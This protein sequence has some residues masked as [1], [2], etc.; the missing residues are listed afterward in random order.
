MKLPALRHV[1]SQLLPHQQRQALK[2]RLFAVRDMSTR[3]ANLKRAGFVPTGAIDGG[4]YHGDWAVEFWSVFPNS[5]VLLIEPQ[6]G[7]RETLNRLV[8]KHAG[9]LV[10]S[11]AVSADSGTADFVLG[12][13]NSFICSP[14]QA[15]CSTVS[16]PV[17][18]LDDILSDTHGF[19]P[20]LLKLDLQGHEIQALEGSV[21]CLDQ[22]EVVILEVSILPIGD[23]PIFTEL[24]SYMEDHGYRLYDVIPQYYRPLDGA[25]WQVDAFYVRNNSPLI[26]SR[27]WS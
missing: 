7:C 24:N 17:K 23:V 15:P 16:V 27:A 20:N 8:Q 11:C 3:L 25:L 26:A 19:Q 10:L 14:S 1:L 6:P 21:S 22:F 18:R 4:A 12:E 13:T 5:P 2:R 9:S